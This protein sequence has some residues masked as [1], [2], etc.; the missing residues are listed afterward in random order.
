[1]T[2]LL[3]QYGLILLFGV[4]AAESAG[5]PLPGETALIAAAV[6]AAQGHYSI[7]SVIAVAA[8]GA[9]I[10]DN[11]GYWLGREG[12]R[13]LLRR[14]PIVRD[15]FERALPRAERFFTRHGSKTVFIA[16]FV[17]VLRVTAAWM[18]GMSRMT[19]WKFLVWNALGGICWA[20]A[21]GTVAYYAGKAAADAISHYGLYVA[22][23]IAAVGVIAG[24]IWW[25][26]RRRNARR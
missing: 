22:G 10:G 15:H 11:V 14:I 5:V 8:A 4:V 7:V 21:Y 19:W 6:L 23:A 25:W 9:I 16:R 18:A 20:A 2:H 24:G 17:A 13:A 1:M 12:G 3:I 26:R